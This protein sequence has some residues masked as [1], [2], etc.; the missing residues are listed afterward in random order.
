MLSRIAWRRVSAMAELQMT[1][2]A[3]WVALAERVVSATAAAT[4]AAI[5]ATALS[6][7]QVDWR[8]VAGVAA[9]TP[10]LT[11][12]KGLAATAVGDSTSPD[13]TKEPK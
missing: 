8:Y 10:I 12:L 4:L 1:T 5:G 7:D 9:L 13:L 3:F 11:I 2:L 6:I